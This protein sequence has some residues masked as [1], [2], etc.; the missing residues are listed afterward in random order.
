[1]IEMEIFV[2]SS[3][4]QSVK[5]KGK[6]LKPYYKMF[7][8]ITIG[9]VRPSSLC[10]LICLN[11]THKYRYFINHIFIKIYCTTTTKVATRTGYFLSHPFHILCY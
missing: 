2:N 8:I 4:H 7:Y 6:L 11:N 1:M 5:S 10:I 3:K 9:T